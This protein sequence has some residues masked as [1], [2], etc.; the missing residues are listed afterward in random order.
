MRVQKFVL[1]ASSH[2]PEGSRSALERHSAA[3]LGFPGMPHCTMKPE[4]T[5]KK[6][7][8]CQIPA[9]MISRKRAAP[10]GAQS[11]YTST[12]NLAFSP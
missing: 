11:G 2:H 10:S 9:S 3:A 12:V 6:R 7:A 1:D 4:T 8:A 5:R